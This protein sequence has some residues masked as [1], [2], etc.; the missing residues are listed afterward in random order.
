MPW[1]MYV[2]QNKD[3]EKD[4]DYNKLYHFSV[5]IE[6]SGF[7]NSQFVLVGRPSL[8]S[9]DYEKKTLMRGDA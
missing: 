7:A 4:E 1:I 9:D 2:F 3:D 8:K 6:Y 5:T